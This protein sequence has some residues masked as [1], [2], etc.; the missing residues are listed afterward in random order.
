MCTHFCISSLQ[1]LWHIHHTHAPRK[2]SKLVIEKI[3]CLKRT[4]EKMCRSQ[5]FIHSLSHS[6]AFSSVV[7]LYIYSSVYFSTQ[8]ALFSSICW[9]IQFFF[10]HWNICSPVM[11]LSMHSF[12]YS[13]R[14][15]VTQ[16]IFYSYAKPAEKKGADEV[17]RLKSLTRH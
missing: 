17:V 6:N 12:I 4:G 15:L 14:N 10:I 13:F 1:W 8:S 9:L 11:Y 2:P 16:S 5:L 7:N 3:K